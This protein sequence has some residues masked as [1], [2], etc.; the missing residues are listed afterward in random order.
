MFAIEQVADVN[1]IYVVKLEGS[2]NLSQ[3]QSALSRVQRKHPALRGLIS[4]EPDGSYFEVD[5][6]P[7]IPLRIVSRLSED[8]CQRECQTELN[9]IFASDQPQ[10]RAV[11]LRSELENDLLLSTSHRICDA[12]SMFTIVK[13]VLR[14][15]HSYEELIPYKTVTTRDL[16][17]D[18]QPQRPW[19]SKL[20]A[21]LF[22]SLLRLIPSS[23]RMPE[24]KEFHLEWKADQLLS[25]TLKQRCKAEGVSVHAF[26]MVALERALFAVF[27]REKLPKW[28]IN[29][30]DL[31]RG[32]FAALKSDMVFFGGGNF[33]ISTVPAP[34]VEFW[35]RVRGVNEKIR[36]EVEREILNIP[37][38]FH[39]IEMLRP[40]TSRQIQW[41]VR[42][43]DAFK[44]NRIS[45]RFGLSELANG[46]WN[47]FGLSNLGNIVINESDAPFRVKDLRLYIHSFNVRMLGLIPYTLDGEM[48]FYCVSDEKCLS[49]NEA[50]SLKLEFIA[51]LQ[52]E[53]SPINTGD[54]KGA[55]MMAAELV[56]NG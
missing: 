40:L 37:S 10:L 1:I 14:A 33:K 19:K 26:L 35:A 15:L 25:D 6:A 46:S 53:F 30:I 50:D 52:R 12:M 48:R 39:L 56:R 28:I 22:N 38:R 7:E 23:S 16:I 45:S 43:G 36:N 44:F 18:Y 32:R 20:A 47:R 11:W 54:I 27:G 21:R 55:P 49:R 34:D 2:F 13:E 17:G 51:L 9:T 42:L 24:N 8:D 41:I 4:D 29:P 31:R 3:L 5:S